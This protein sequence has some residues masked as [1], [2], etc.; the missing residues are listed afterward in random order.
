MTTAVLADVHANLPALESVLAEVE[1]S[2]AERVLVLGDVVG[3]GASPA[4]CVERV[5]EAADGAVM[6]NHDFASLGGGYQP[7]THEAARRAL[8]WTRSRLDVSARRFLSSL[9]ACSVDLGMVM[10]H[11]CF[12]NENAYYR[13]YTTSTTLGRN[14]EAVAR[15]PEWP[16]VAVCGHTHVPMCAW[17][18]DDEA[19]EASPFHRVTWPEDAQAVLINPGSVGQPRDG[20]PR[21]AFAL[22]DVDRRTVELR[23][24]PYDV[25]RAAAMVT[26]AGLPDE[27]ARRLWRGT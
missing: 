8:Q 9:P 16:S 23:R 10:A 26:A 17:L 12:L 5:R 6:G 19:V 21:A 14:L 2:G 22:V 27:L 24:V 11:G 15:H 4:E 20:D 25:G 13:G 1:A 7:G 3:Y 18:A